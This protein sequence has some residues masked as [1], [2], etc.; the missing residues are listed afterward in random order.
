MLTKIPYFGGLFV[1]VLSLYWL[2][3][4]NYKTTI[5]INFDTLTKLNLQQLTRVY[6]R[7]DLGCNS[8]GFLFDH[9]SSKKDKRISAAIELFGGMCRI[10]RIRATLQALNR[11]GYSIVILDRNNSTTSIT[12]IL[13]DV[14]LNE[15]LYDLLGCD[16]SNL[17]DMYSKDP[18]IYAF[19]E[20]WH[21]ANTC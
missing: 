16:Y 17:F 20:K 11:M 6:L 13:I 18:Q 15:Y 21:L 3:T 14:E 10:K 1:G 19:E 12:Q 8:I 5:I 2:Y 7:G 9:R 4:V